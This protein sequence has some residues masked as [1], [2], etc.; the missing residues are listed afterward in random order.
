MQFDWDEEKAARNEQYHDVSFEEACEA[1]DDDL[2]V[3]LADDAHS[4][5]EQ[6]FN[7]IGMVGERLL[8]VVYTER[9]K[10][11]IIRIISAR[12]AEPEEEEIYYAS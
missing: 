1:F 11:A 10:G 2:A 3:V 6:R 7:L 12:E 9:K 8:F 5:N 4:W